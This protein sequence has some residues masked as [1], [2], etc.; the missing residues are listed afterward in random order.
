MTYTDLEISKDT[1]STCGNCDGTGKI[2]VYGI[3]ESWEEVCPNCR[4][5]TPTKPE[6]LPEPALTALT[7]ALQGGGE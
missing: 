5:M 6:A 7:A 3:E 1:D 4:E 2:L